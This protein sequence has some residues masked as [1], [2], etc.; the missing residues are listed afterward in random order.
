MLTDADVRALPKVSLH[1]HLDGAVRPA[2]LID[3]RSDAHLP[4]P[5]R[6][7]DE[8]AQS[9]LDRS[10]SRSLPAYLSS[11]ALVTDALQTHAALE[12]AAHEFVEDL[13][14]DGVIYAEVRWAPAQHTHG[15]MSMD[16]AVD[17]VCAGLASGIEAMRRTGRAIHVRQLLTALRHERHSVSTAELAIRRR[18]DGIVGFDIAGPEAGHGLGAHQEALDLVAHHCLPRTIHAGEADGADSIRSALV[19]AR[20][21]RIGHGVRIAEDLTRTDRGGEA[22]TLGP[23]AAWV[24]DCRVPLEL[25]PTSNLHTGATARWGTTL[26][27]HPFDQLYRLGFTV[28]VNVDNRTMSATTLTQEN[29]LLA[30]TFG[31]QMADLLQFQRNAANATFLTQPERRELLAL[32]DAHNINDTPEGSTR[33]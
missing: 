17:A 13:A 5:T 21:Q 16:G 18:A 6:D 9:I 33:E 2:T 15:E 11:F 1:D 27:D 31:Y 14:D 32:I 10:T 4:L 22:V 29:Q 24:R 20:A 26:A 28:T 23:V 25:S 7:P 8:L 30:N 19:D 3:L 12:R